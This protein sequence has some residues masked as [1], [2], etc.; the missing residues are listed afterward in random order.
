MATVPE[1]R[2]TRLAVLGGMC[3]RWSTPA[4]R[5]LRPVGRS[6]GLLMVERTVRR[7]ELRGGPQP[8]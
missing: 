1:G 5:A 7:A 3:R 8:A 6:R 2:G 4:Q